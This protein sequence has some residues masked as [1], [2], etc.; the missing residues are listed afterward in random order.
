MPAVGDVNHDW[1]F[2]T[3][4]VAHHC[5]SGTTGPGWGVPAVAVPVMYGQPF[6]AS[7][8]T[9]LGVAPAATPFRP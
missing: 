8:L 9:A 6:W 2:P 7:R 4:A 3:A 5:G 1:P